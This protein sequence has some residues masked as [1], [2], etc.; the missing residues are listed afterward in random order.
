M[1]GK[2]TLGKVIILFG[3]GLIFAFGGLY[4]DKLLYS[5]GIYIIFLAGIFLTMVKEDDSK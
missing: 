3:A 4:F 5:L 1:K 2:L